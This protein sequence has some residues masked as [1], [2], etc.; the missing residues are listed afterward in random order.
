MCRFR[1]RRFSPRCRNHE[2]LIPQLSAYDLVG[3]QTENDATNFARYLENECR[4]QKRGAFA[5]QTAD[6]TVRVG[7][8]PDRHRDQRVQPPGAALGPLG[9]GARRASKASPA[10]P[11]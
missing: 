7:V 8:F 11:W 2:W 4:L 5:Y 6:R 1:R 3:L 9:P 10:G